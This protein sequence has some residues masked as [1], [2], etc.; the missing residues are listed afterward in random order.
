LYW[1][2]IVLVSVSFI[3]E[4]AMATVTT[5]YSSRAEL[6]DYLYLP[7]VSWQTY[8]NLRRES[9]DS[10][11]HLRITFDRGE[12]EIMSPSR[13]HEYKKRFIGR[14]IETYTEELNTPISSVGSTTFKDELKQKGL[15]PDECY[16]VQNE[17]LVR[18]LEEI[19]LGVDPPP[20]L[21]IE[22]DITTTVVK[23]LPIYAAFAFP[24]IWRYRKGV[25]EVHLLGD[26]GQY[27][28][29]NSSKCFPKLPITKLTEFLSQA[30]QT[31]ETTWIRSFR[32]WV[33]ESLTA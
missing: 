9:D 28:I 1:N 32:A 8:V 5:E 16:Y 18:D 31:D 24:E 2:E 15:E 26:D 4:L 10:G 12:M 33:R 6:S 20:D 25:I 3:C 23:R 30:G 17:A 14:M 7:E 13:K 21:A 19:K 27:Q 29:S 11:R 22:I